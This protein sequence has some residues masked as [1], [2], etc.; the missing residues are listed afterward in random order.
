MARSPAPLA[1][2]ALTAVTSLGLVF[3]AAAGQ[4]LGTD[5]GRGSEFCE[6]ARGDLVLQPANSLSNLGFVVAGLLIGWYAGSAAGRLAHRGLATTFA[7]IVVLL[8]PGSMAMHATQTSLGGRIDQFSMYLVAGFAAA[9]AVTRRLGLSS[10]GFTGLFLALVVTCEAV[11]QL[12]TLPV[13][14]NAGNAVFGTLLLVCVVVEWRLRS[15]TPNGDLR[16]ILGAVGAMAAGFT[17]WSLSQTGDGL[18]EPHSWLQGHAF[19]HLMCALAAYCIYR[20]WASEEA[21][22][23]SA[24]PLR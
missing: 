21:A 17:V 23:A 9:Y 6:A 10:V 8:G 1:I 15:R 2:A 11:E 19:W 12:G 14:H 4:R 22:Q 16:W 13:V 24:D 3:A 18:C 20:Y 7:V 5:L